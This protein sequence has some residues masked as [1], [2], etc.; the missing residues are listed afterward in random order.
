MRGN[1]RGN[2]HPF[3]KTKFKMLPFVGSAGPEAYLDWELADTKTYLDW[4]LAIEQK[5]NSHLVPKEHRVRLATSEFTRFALFWWN[6]ICNDVNANSHNII[7]NQKPPPKSRSTL[8]GRRL[9]SV[10]I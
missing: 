9:I 1:D 2:S 6:D 7:K 8:K 5:F 10:I 4:E 3:A